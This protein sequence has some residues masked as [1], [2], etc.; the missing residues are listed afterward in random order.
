MRVAIR[1][2]DERSAI[3][4][5]HFFGRIII[6]E[7]HTAIGGKLP[8][9][10]TGEAGRSRVGREAVQQARLAA[11]IKVPEEAPLAWLRQGRASKPGDAPAACLQS[12]AVVRTDW[13][14]HR[15]A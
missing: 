3:L 4:D 2:D 7:T 10:A 14:R 11:K 5:K 1:S 6:G 13:R 8:T 15:S 9:K 12:L